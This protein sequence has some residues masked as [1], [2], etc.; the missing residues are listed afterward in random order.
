[1]IVKRILFP[2][3]VMA[4][5][6]CQV[7]ES[8][9]DEIEFSYSNE[10][11]IPYHTINI[12]ISKSYNNDSAV[13]FIQSKPL[14]D[15]PKW[16][17]SK[18]DTIFRIDQK[19][20]EKLTNATASLDKIDMDK[21]EQKGFDGSTWKIE[22]GSKGKN[23]SYRFWSPNW[24]TKKRGLVDFIKLSEQFIKISKLKKDEVLG[25]Y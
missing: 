12:N 1:M 18:I 22:F 19:T 21:A 6:S 25:D 13:V 16:A 20:F 15:I 10:R 5:L 2:L 4:F 23:K 9:I 17:Y 8:K 24:E 3:I 11:R 7:Q 14:S